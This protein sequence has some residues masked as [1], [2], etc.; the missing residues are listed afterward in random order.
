MLNWYRGVP[1]L[2]WFFEFKWVCEFSE[3]IGEFVGFF[4]YCK[5]CNVITV[6]SVM[7]LL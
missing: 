1:K 6:R 3:K 2:G 5:K 4:D 7:A